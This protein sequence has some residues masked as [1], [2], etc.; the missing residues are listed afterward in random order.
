MKARL[1]AALA[2][3]LA[4]PT[5]AY[6]CP[7]CFDA[8]AANRTAFIV[9]TIFLSFLPLAMVGGLVYWIRQLTREQ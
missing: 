2:L 5:V 4:S 8:N 7:V 9:T 3:V 6:A 1:A